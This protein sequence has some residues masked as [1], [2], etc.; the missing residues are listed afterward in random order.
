MDFQKDITASI[1]NSSFQNHISNKELNKAFE[2]WLK[3][4]KDVADI[5]APWKEFTRQTDTKFN[6]WYTQELAELKEQKNKYLKLYRIHRNPDDLAVYKNIKNLQTHLTRRLKRSYYK[7][8]IDEYDGDSKKIWHLLKDVTNL[9]YKDEI[10]PDNLNKNTANK[11][12]VFFATVGKVVQ[13]KLKIN[14]KEPDLNKGQFKFTNVTEKEVSQL[15]KRIR[16]DVATGYDEISSRLVKAAA[17][18]ILKHVKEMINLSYET[19]TFPDAFKRANVKILHKSDDNNDPAQY[20]PISILTTISKIFE[21]NAVEQ[22]MS[23]L[24]KNKKL[25]P[26]QHAYKP[27]YSTATCLFEL[28]ESIR[29]H[30]DQKELVAIA[31]LDLS[32]AFDSL[33]HELI[34]EKL[35][36]KDIDHTAVKWIKSYLLDRKQCVKFGDILSDEEYVKSGVPQGSILGPLLFI[37]CTDDLANTMKEYE[38]FSY[39]DDTQII[40]TGKNKNEIENHLT[41]AIKK[42]N[43]Y[44]NK[45]SLLNNIGKTKIML[46]QNKRS[47]VESIQIKVKEDAKVKTLEGQDHLKILGIKIDKNLDWNK[48]ISYVKKNATNSIRNLH[49]VNNLLPLKQKR[50]LYNSLVVPHFSYCDII[51]NELSRENEKKL[52]LA[53]N[54]AARSMLG[55]RKNSSATAALKQ[56]ELLPLIEKRNIHA[57]VQVKKALS[58]QTPEHISLQYTNLE[59]YKDLRPGN[60]QVPLHKTDQYKKGPLFSS[61]KIWN[62][63]PLEIKNLGLDNFKN[64]YQKYKLQTFLSS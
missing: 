63:I 24:M 58:G 15:I 8:K 40:V 62:S 27:K 43:D 34:L 12:N 7:K 19:E 50:I 38:T 3:T 46:F 26:K 4:I 28:I 44:Y 47:N 16:P 11:F 55:L 31:S 48:H 23:F 64:T 10:L 54:F 41:N 60:L 52:Q 21:R 53:Q 5:H 37:I 25:N 29:K 39:A 59:R 13:N 2:Q 61:V 22:L 42:A 18:A 17:P 33:A 32:K 57:A 35:I 49:R 9:N 1:N 45:N 36:N 20:R 56:L 51:W 6:P 30:L 14:I